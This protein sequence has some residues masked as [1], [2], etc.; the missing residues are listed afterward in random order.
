MNP[1]ASTVLP[2]DAQPTAGAIANPFSTYGS[3]GNT[4]V[5][6][7]MPATNVT[8][9]PVTL[10]P[11]S[12]TSTDPLSSLVAQATAQLQTAQNDTTTAENK[13]NTSANSL[14]SLMASL[15]GQTGD[16]IQAQQQQ[17][18]PQLSNDIRNLQLDIQGKQQKYLQ[19]LTNI[20]SG[21]IRS[22]S[23]NQNVALSRQNAIDVAIASSQLQAKQGNL[24]YANEIVKN[25]IDAKYAPIKEAIETQ[26][27]LLERDD[28]NLSRADARLATE[29]KNTLD[30]K[31]KEIDKKIAEDK[32]NQ[33]MIINANASGAPIA[34]T[35]RA[36]QMAKEGK[37][38]SEIANVLREYAGDYYKTQLLK[39]Q[40]QTERAQRAKIYSDITP[41]SSSATS[42]ESGIN[43]SKFKDA[44]ART[45]YQVVDGVI[46][47]SDSILNQTGDLSGLGNLGGSKIERQLDEQGQKN[48]GFLNA[49]NLKVQQW[50]SGASLTSEQIKQVNALV[51]SSNDSETVI[52]NKLA[53][54][55]SYMQNEQDS[56]ARGQGQTPVRKA[57]TAQPN[58][59]QQAQGIGSSQPFQGTSIIKSV[60][61][62]GSIDF[63]IPKN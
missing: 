52:R 15:S 61:N 32:T 57:A 12:T 48:R 2:K 39:E 34:L 38:P 33:D 62:S 10:P 54:L 46:S 11:P 36:Q 23:Q 59:F 56:I 45:Q 18:I 49:V 8:T 9:T 13:A 63:T 7:S 51:P 50:A 53:S 29:R 3:I 44:S 17:G 47:A 40:I 58:I 16:T 55:K 19:G 41:Q 60:T 35:S 28:K 4:V 27:F 42:S 24:I 14:Q 37:S 43:P 20:E 21:N 22:L 5:P 31:L 30:L 25:A 6:N 26:K 1:D